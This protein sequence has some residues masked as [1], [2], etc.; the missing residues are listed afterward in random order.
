MS[1]EHCGNR[2]AAEFAHTH[3]KL[4]G[5][6]EGAQS[7]TDGRPAK[8]LV[9]AL[10]CTHGPRR[11]GPPG[12]LWSP[13]A[14]G[15]AWVGPEC[16]MAAEGRAGCRSGAAACIRHCHPRFAIVLTPVWGWLDG[17]NGARGAPNA[18]AGNCPQMA[19]WTLDS[20]DKQ[21]CSRWCSARSGPP[22]FGC[23][24]ARGLGSTQVSSP[25]TP[26]SATQGVAQLGAIPANLLPSR[27]A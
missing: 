19:T 17:G 1:V 11:V 7:A 14:G 16:P 4:P 27:P 5:L 15:V 3:P 10:R 20:V 9:R 2:A 23:G 22:Q 12:G 26:R 6:R 24:G 13:H 21:H 18:L 25:Q 8:G